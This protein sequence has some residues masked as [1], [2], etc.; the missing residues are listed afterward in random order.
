VNT[1]RSP[2]SA[3]ILMTMTFLASTGAEAQ[4]YAGPKCLGPVC[5]DRNP[6]FEE[7]AQRLGGPSSAGGIYGYRTNNAEAFLIITD[8]GH[9][10]LGSI[11]LRDFAEYG[12][13][14]EKDGKLAA[15]DIRNWKTPEEIGL[16]SQEADIV[17]A[18]GKP[19]GVEDLE[20]EDSSRERGKRLLIYKGQLEGAVR[21]ARFRLRDGRVSFIEFENDAF[22]GPDCLGPYCT[23]GELT[24]NSLFVGLGLPQKNRLSPLVCFQSQDAQA[25]LHFSTDVEETFGVADVLLSDFP[26]CLHASKK[27]TPNRIRAWKTPEGIGL[28]SS[29]EDVLK[30]YGRP[31][32]EKKLQAQK[33]VRETKGLIAG[34][35]AGDEE[36]RVGD[37]IIIYGPR[38]LQAVDFG[39]RDGRVSYIWLKVSDFW[40]KD[41]Q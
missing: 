3:A 31:S 10:D 14:T 17:K 41:G 30:A 13:W 7:L 29:E 36:T 34:H 24:P 32:A 9:G 12:N 16:G 21:V 8:G 5:M 19:S 26:N 25:F 33:P 4:V 18:Y 39:I 28:G 27:I 40:L 11:S 15:Q 6:S 35:R 2:A 23:Y 38:E 22:V 37:K 20:L 1:L